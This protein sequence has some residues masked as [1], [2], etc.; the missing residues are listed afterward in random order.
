[1]AQLDE[2]F[3]TYFEDAKYQLEQAL[4]AETNSNQELTLCFSRAAILLGFSAFEA[5]VNSITDDFVEGGFPL[6]IH[7][8]GILLDKEV[9]FNDG[10]EVSEKSKFSRLEDKLALVYICMAKKPLN[11][12]SSMWS[13][14]VTALKQRNEL[15]HSRNKV[16]LT[17]KS[18]ERTLR[19]I[20]TFMGRVTQDV[21]HRPLPLASRDL[22]SRYLP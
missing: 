14:F 17:A 5:F 13:D 6:S 1:M 9:R 20:L 3:S 16:S 7:E 19:T 22:L 2:V 8:K 10:F 11:R 21:Y 4:K 15:V 12:S 18:A